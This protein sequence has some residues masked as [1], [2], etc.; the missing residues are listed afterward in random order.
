MK[1]TELINEFPPELHKPIRH[2]MDMVL[3]NRD[4]RIEESLERLVQA[5]ARTEE[6]VT[7]LEAAIERLAQAQARTEE[8]VTRLEE[9]VEKLVQAQ[10]RT[11]D[12]LT[13][14][15]EAVEKLVQAQMRTDERVTGLESS[16]ERFRYEFD[17]KLGGLGARWG[18]DSEAA[19]R[20]GLREILKTEGYIVENYNTYDKEGVVF[21]YPSSVELDIIIHNGSLM[22]VEIKSGISAG[23]VVI[24]KKKCDF[25]TTITG[26]EP[27]KRIIITP[28]PDPKSLDAALNFE[29]IVVT[30]VADIPKNL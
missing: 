14:L 21:A 7:G 22:L 29:I 13:R 16:M 23:D 1:I 6:R 18:K 25:Y 5:Q 15:E 10:I 30:T 20:N 26:K 9:A 11:E 28:Y 4:S 3:E 17:F 27:A 24:F 12:R 8:R 19:F 2:L